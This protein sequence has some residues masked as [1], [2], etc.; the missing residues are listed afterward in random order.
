MAIS[1]YIDSIIRKDSPMEKTTNL[2]TLINS[3]V[4]S[5]TGSVVGRVRS[6]HINPIN[7]GLEGI[8]VDRSLGKKDVYLGSSYIDR[9]T[10][11]GIILTIEPSILLVGKRVLDKNG[12]GIGLVKSIN[13]KNHTNE[14]QSV[15][16]SS[17]FKK[18]FVIPWNFINQTTHVLVILPSHNVKQKYFWQ[19]S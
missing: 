14:V 16:V 8:C 17:L 1:H 12:K 6:I 11:E 13:R 7:L 4:I 9:A 5:K 15:V 2:K 10:N 19:K 18:D 3:R